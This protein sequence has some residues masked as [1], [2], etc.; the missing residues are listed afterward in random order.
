MLS[1]M[2]GLQFFDR[3]QDFTVAWKR[4]PHWAQSGT[5]TFITWRTVDSLPAAALERIARERDVTLRRFGI[6]P[7]GDPRGRSF[8]ETPLRRQVSPKLAGKL[9]RLSPRDKARLNWDLFC[10]WDGLVY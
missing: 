10:V 3:R 6:E 8:G 1:R 2:D 5:V 4:L 7:D 9:A